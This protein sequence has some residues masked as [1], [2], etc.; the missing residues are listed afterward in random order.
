MVG[1]FDTDRGT[2]NQ[3][4]VEALGNDRKAEGSLRAGSDT[5][6]AVWYNS[7]QRQFTLEARMELADGPE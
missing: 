7:G 5:I 4:C 1:R 2:K 3:G 6:V